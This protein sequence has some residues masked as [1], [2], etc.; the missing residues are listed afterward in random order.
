[1]A[2]GTGLP[3]A[4]AQRSLADWPVVLAAWLLLVCATTLLATGVVYG[5]AVASGG[6][7]RALLA[8]PPATRAL[9]VGLSTE[10]DRLDRL[11]GAVRPEVERAM[12]ATGG[13]VVRVLRSGSF[14]DRAVPAANVQ[15]LTLFASVDGLEKMVTLSAGAWPVAGSDP[16]QATLSDAAAREMELG[17]GDRVALV[18]RLDPDLT[19]SAVISGIW[20]V[21]P[22][23]GLWLGEPL[24]TTG[25]TTGGTYTTR[26]PLLVQEADLLALGGGGGRVDVSWRGLPAIGALRV[27]GVNALRA[28]ANDLAARLRGAVP[29][30]TS[31]RVTTG[32]PALLDDVGRSVLVS[33]SGVILLTIQFAV[34][35]G[36]AVVLVAGMLVERRRSEIALIRSRGGSSFHLIAM[37]VLEA[38]FL[39]VPAALIAPVLALGVV[40]LLGAVGPT[41]GLG[42]TESASIGQGA[43]IVSALAGLVSIAA[44]TLPTLAVTASPHG[45]RAA[46][47]RQ[48][49][50]TLGQRLGLDLALVAVAGV[51]LWQLRLYGAP[52][53]RNVQGTLGLDPLLVAAP[54]IG[55]VGGAVLALRVVPR[56]AELGER[57]LVRGRGL[58]GSLGGRQLARRPLRYTRAALLLMLAAALG[59]LAAAHGAT[60]TRSQ[61]DQAAF[62]AVADVRALA[63]DYSSLPTWAA[64]PTYRAIEGVRSA[65]PVSSAAFD[66]GRTIREGALV[67]LNP[68]AVRGLERHRSGGAPAAL[69]ALASATQQVP[70]PAVPVPGTP[71]RIAV[72]V[73]TTFEADPEVGEATIPPGARGLNVALVLR[74]GDGRLLR[75]TTAEGLLDGAGQRLVVTL[76]DGAAGV[77]PTAPLA[78]EAVELTIQ[79][80]DPIAIYGS[81]ELVGIEV[82]EAAD[83]DG[84][85]AGWQPV[86]VSAADDGWGWLRIDPNAGTE[87]YTST[88]QA[89]NR[90]TVGRGAAIFGG[91][92]QSGPTFRLAAGPPPG[93]AIPVIASRPF[94]ARTGAAV[95]DEVGVT[96]SGR[97]VKVRVVAVVDAFAPYDPAAPFLLADLATLDVVRFTATGRTVQAD[98]WWL[99]VDPGHEAAAVA[100]LRARDAGTSEVIGRE[101]L[102]RSLQTD[103]VPLGLIGILGLGSLAAMLFAGIGFL[104][105]AT[106][107]TNE[108][109]GEFALMRALGLST[110]QLSLWLSI[111]SVFLLAV[112][113]VAGSGLGLLLAWL[114]LPFAT[115]TQTGLPPIP[116]PEV[117]VPWEAIVPIYVAAIVLFVVSLWLVRRQLPDI[118]ISGVLRAGES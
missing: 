40:A 73:D 101:E 45:A 20:I 13:D 117:V 113:L 56:I 33:R 92:G 52:L 54:A 55:L 9:E 57:L 43:V 47:G 109:I 67:G 111:E 25:T 2:R 86:T 18:G 27:D 112:G 107:S 70:V 59:T 46:T 60:W 5:D 37:A 17:I 48:A 80:L 35:A 39:A 91:L 49:R 65:T 66:V 68:A 110:G 71:A 85:E 10:I 63:S 69:D 95:G 36:Y 26:G 84:P 53:T 44:L 7:H 11:D 83:G 41:A 12:A 61:S 6:L 106:I 29:A 50:T 14:A 115:L 64:G 77:R 81:A 74:D 76:S 31:P 30:S 4:V 19:A 28:G 93:A 15:D 62:R 8:A 75:T 102:T 88:G 78:V 21:D 24:M 22:D 79:A 90:V 82:S 34:L 94:L 87:P 104:V 96:S 118:R 1:M 51:A 97:T 99:A 72:L 23:A 38:T 100:A 16:I 3:G 32:L 108:R 103:P 58:V 116:A 98:E 89:P 114:V 42:L 105:S